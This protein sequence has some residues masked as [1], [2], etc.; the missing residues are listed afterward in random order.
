MSIG[1]LR[2]KLD[3]GLIDQIASGWT[4]GSKTLA[5]K[6]KAKSRPR[7][8][9]TYRWFRRNALKNPKRPA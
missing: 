9:E 1:R 8:S 6:S 3:V 5:K 4:S 2:R 7:G